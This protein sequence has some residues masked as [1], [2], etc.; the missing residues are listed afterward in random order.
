MAQQYYKGVPGYKKVKRPDKEVPAHKC[1]DTL[2]DLLVSI[3]GYSAN[4]AGANIEGVPIKETGDCEIEIIEA[5]EG[6]KG[7]HANDA[8]L[9]TLFHQVTYVVYEL[10]NADNPDSPQRVSFGSK[11]AETSKN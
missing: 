4:I 1:G 5:T 8:L 10:R 7:Q 2:P 11:K 9:G 3:G 6:E